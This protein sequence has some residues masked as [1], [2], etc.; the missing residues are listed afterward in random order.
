MICVGFD[1]EALY[2][3]LDCKEVARLIEKAVMESK[4]IW[5]DLDYQEGARWLAL[6]YSEEWCRASSLS[7]VLPRRRKSKGGGKTRKLKLTQVS[8]LS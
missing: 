1:V 3:S 2:P 8:K 6:N 4:I 5:K 7:R